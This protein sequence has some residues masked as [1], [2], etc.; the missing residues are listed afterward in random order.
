MMGVSRITAIVISTRDDIITTFG[1]PDPETGKYMGWITLPA[2][3]RYRPLLNTEAIYD[4]PE[5]AEAAMN[6]SVR[7]IRAELERE[8]GAV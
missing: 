1:G 5:E 8:M 3:D 6:E 2:E 7:V 4:S